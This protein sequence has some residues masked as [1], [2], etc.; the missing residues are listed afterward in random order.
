MYAIIVTASICI[1]S[2]GCYVED[3][4]FGLVEP[5]L[6]LS[7]EELISFSK[8]HHST[9]L[10]VNPLGAGPVAAMVDVL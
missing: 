5:N 6:Q 8:S 3:Q 4:P 2:A 7:I 9:L 1:T 10:N